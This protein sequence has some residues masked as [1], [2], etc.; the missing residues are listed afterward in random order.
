[1][2]KLRPWVQQ[3]V[4]SLCV[5]QA[6]L[7]DADS[8]PNAVV[9]W[10]NNADGETNVPPA[11][12]NV[13]AIAGGDYHN[14]VLQS[15]GTVVA[16]GQNV[17]GQTT[18]P[19][20][21]TNVAAIAGGGYHS[22]ALQS[23]GTVAAWGYNGFGQTSVPVGLTNVD[24]IAGG[25]FH[26][27][28]LQSNGT[29]VAWGFNDYDQ[30]SVPP[31]LSNVIAIAGGGYHSLALQTN[32]DVVAW[33]YNGYGQTSVP[34]GLSNVTAIAAG[35][36]HSLAL[37]SNGTVVAWGYN[38]YGQTSVPPGLS[39][40]TA[41]A[42]GGY[43]NLALLS[44]A[45]VAAWGDNVY[46]ET[47][48]P[49]GLSNVVAIAGGLEHSLAI[50]PLLLEPPPAVSLALGT[51]TNLSF[52]A[53]F[54]SPFSCQWSLNGIPIAGATGTSLLISNFDLTAAG[55]Y[56]VAITN[57]FRSATLSTVVRLTNSPIVLVDG[58]DVGGGA[59][60]RTNVSQ[61]TM[62]SAFGLDAEIYYTLDGS[63]PDFAAIPY[64]GAFTLTNSATI[65]A[66]AYNFAYTDWAAAAPISLQISPV[67][68]LSAGSPGGG[69]IIASPLGYDG[70]NLYL[71]NTVVTL[72]AMPSNGWS[73]ASWTG[74][75]SATTNVT[76]VVMDQPRAVQALFDTSL[77][78]FTNGSGQVL[79]TPPA[80]SY[81]FGSTVQLT[82]LPS[83]GYYFFGWANAASGFANPF[84]FTVTNDTPGI[85]A[86]FEAL[87][88]SQVSLAVLPQGNGTVLINPA[89]NVYT[90]GDTV[91]LT[92]VP[93]SNCLFTGWSGDAAGSLN[94]LVLTLDSDKF[95][96][97][98]FTVVPLFQ[99]V[100]Q[101][102]GTLT[103]AWT[104]ATGQTYQVQYKTN[105]L[106]T[107]WISLG[108]PNL[109][110]NDIMSASDS[111]GP[112]RQRFYRV[113]LLP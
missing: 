12:A 104:A 78:L 51:D 8:Q 5:L 11:L 57:Q 71:S 73:F 89:R 81:L 88:P 75:S 74:D 20:G 77:T 44:D 49:T 41:I 50:A 72:T 107:N 100:M 33:G 90:N 39:N 46:G 1:M 98:N 83:P 4:I 27:L 19:A 55:F 30:T 58:V 112:D 99:T 101:S 109:A 84:L 113:I 3:I 95:I 67:F 52:T 45:T 53:W 42:A 21:L 48:V 14:L 80:G 106:Q 56:S 82:A 10:G 25:G 92:A 65:R 15:N 93:A 85:T 16:W 18:V 105:L 22:L 66:I 36:Y 43:H 94:P 79:L 35:D 17:Y 70:G 110:T 6:P 28:A 111:T 63:E 102:A 31:G 86:L 59:V 97:A 13:A 62:T 29:V 108:S 61:I 34:P 40:V 76:A 96:L 26:S 91:T 24:A 47:N 38:G 60:S 32:G 54:G 87:K 9:A 64:S 7:A 23:N 37:Q 68:L 2:K 103:L 69:G